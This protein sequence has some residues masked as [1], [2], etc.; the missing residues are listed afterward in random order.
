MDESSKSDRGFESRNIRV[1]STIRA[2]YGLSIG[3]P[4]HL[5]KIDGHFILLRVT[6][7]REY[8]MNTK[9][10]YC[11]VT[12]KNFSSLLIASDGDAELHRLL[13]LTLGCDPELFLANRHTGHLIHA[14]RLFKKYGDVGNDGILLEFRPS[15]SVD[16]AEVT[17][18]IRNLIHKA[19]AKLNSVP[20][21]RDICMI[22]S[23]HY[24][25][26]AAGFHLHYGLPKG[27]LGY[28][29][30]VKGMARMVTLA[31]DYYAGT[32]AIIP[33]G[34][35]DCGRRT[36]TRSPYGKPGDM[37][38]DHRT[39]EY[40]LPGGNLL[41]HPLLTQGI[42]ALGAIVIEDMACR[43]STWTDMFAAPHLIRSYDDMVSLY[44]NLPSIKTLFSTICS[45]NAA[46]ARERLPQIVEDVRSM[47]GYKKRAHSVEPFFQCLF[48]GTVFDNNIERNWGGVQNARQ[49]GQMG[50]L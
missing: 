24:K 1:P 6:E 30:N 48:D 3:D 5:R 49:Q 2:E 50:L 32:L 35:I 46:L 20:E 33:E 13:G 42:L 34:S 8:D 18:N 9:P 7:A 47:V 15:P 4:V 19:R 17:H 43:I 31:L 23:S 25:G 37:R 29:T 11:F 39:F 41:R 26:M 44:P 45:P 40:R 12:S 14:H 10:G 27:M 16:E 38:L 36:D 22:A 21:G 28:N